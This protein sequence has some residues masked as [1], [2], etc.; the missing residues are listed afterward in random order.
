MRHSILKVNREQEVFV[1]IFD[2]L[3]MQFVLDQCLLS[4]FVKFT[5]IFQLHFS[6]KQILLDPLQNLCFWALEWDY[7]VWDNT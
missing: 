1:D 4:H 7:F 6:V 3:G 2:L 5:L